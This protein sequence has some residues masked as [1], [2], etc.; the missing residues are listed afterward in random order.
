M[1]IKVEI[2]WEYISENSWSG[3]L[4]TVREIEKQD[5]E[6]EAL[7][8]I[9]EYIGDGSGCEIPTETEFNDF[10]WFDLADIMNLY[11]DSEKEDED[12]EDDEEE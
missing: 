7:A 8:I 12:E 3:A 1:F 5:R 9:E 4:D 2:D 11:G 10:V 6:E